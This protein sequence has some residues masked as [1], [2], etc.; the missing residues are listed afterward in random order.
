MGNSYKF[1]GLANKQ[2]VGVAVNKDGDIELAVK[3]NKAIERKPASSYAR[4]LLK[5]HMRNHNC[6]A[7]STVTTLTK[8]AYYRAD[9]TDFAVA[10]Y[11]AMYKSL[12][13]DKS[14][15]KT[16][17]RKRRGNKA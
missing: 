6:K 10:R 7:A 8:G 5:K 9:L 17:Q 16:Q 3:K 1:S 4:T 14:A 2:T 12:K 11:H 13:A 15:D